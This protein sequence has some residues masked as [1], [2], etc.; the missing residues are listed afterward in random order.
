MAFIIE[1]KTGDAGTVIMRGCPDGT[2]E[3]C[4]WGEQTDTATKTKKPA[5]I[6]YKFYANIEQAFNR[7]LSMRVSS[8]EADN[9]KDLVQ[10]IRSIRADIKTE[11][12]GLV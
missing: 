4:K 10:G 6:P 5:L 7:V 1:V 9:I 11:M 2:V 3:F 12:G 8:Y